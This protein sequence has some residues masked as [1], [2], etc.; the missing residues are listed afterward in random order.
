MDDAEAKKAMLKA[1]ELAH[2]ARTISSPVGARPA[3][4]LSLGPFGATL[5]PTQ[6]FLG[7][8][9]PP[10]GPQAYTERGPKVKTFTDPDD[11]RA[12]VH[13]L[14]QFH[15]ERLLIYSSDAT[16]WNAIEYIAF[17][18][19]LLEREVVAI[20]YAMTL[21]AAHISQC[22]DA[23]DRQPKF[24]W[25]SFVCPDVETDIE[26]LALA[27]LDERRTSQLYDVP[28]GIGINCTSLQTLPKFIARI[29]EAVTHSTSSKTTLVLYPNGGEFD[30]TNYIN[31]CWKP[32]T[33]GDSVRWATQFADMLHSLVREGRWK[34]IIAG[35][36]CQT[37]A[38][39]IEALTSRLDPCLQV[40]DQ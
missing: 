32:R 6:E 14:A 29:S 39:H 5:R 30:T 21:F 25:I 9:P 20:R 40:Q 2:Q 31:P 12:A 4:A 19:V 15:L 34:N 7:F 16:L 13:A 11:E 22:T 38:T 27:A 28:N 23:V 26:S 37:D 3:L 35:G 33:E 17:E 24:W 18:T 36:C 10:F 1:V 8:Y